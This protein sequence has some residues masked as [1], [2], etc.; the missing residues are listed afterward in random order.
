M[1]NENNAPNNCQ[2]S[3]VNYQSL[4]KKYWGYD[5]FRGIQKEIIESIGAGKDTL[6]LMPT[7]GGK[8]ITFQV[9]ALA[10]EG[11]CIVITPLIALMKDQ[12][13]N[14]RRRG[15]Q[16]SAIYS[17]MKHDSILMTLENAVF[18]GVKILYISPE[19]ISTSLFL[20]KLRHMKVSFI[21]VDEAH[22]ISQWGYDFRPSYL[23]IAD[24]RKELPDT[25]VLALTATATPEVIDD[26]QERLHFRE[27]CVY[28]MSFARKNLAYVVRH[29]SNKTGQLIH[30]LNHVQ[31][32]AIVYVR[33][34]KRTKEYAELLN[35]SGISATFY[36]AG[37]DN[38]EK[39]QRQKA[40]QEDKV[41]VMVATNAF[42]MG[43][44]KPDVR[45]VIHI[46]CP[47]CLEAYFQE[48]GRAGRDGKKSYAVLLYD[49]SDRA[50]LQRRVVDTFPDKDF[51]RQVY[52]QL[53]YFY[54]IGVGSGYNACFEFP[55]ERF[56]RIYKHFPIPTVSALNILTRAGY[57]DFKEEDDMQARVM[58]SVER[59]DLYKLRGN[60]PQEDAVI[61]ALLRNYTGL[62][63]GY[64]YIDEGV[65]AEQCGLTQPQVYMTLRALT[66]KHILDFIPQK[67]IPFIRYTQRREES[68]RLVI[69]KSIYD[70]LKI[71]FAER[72]EKML[73][74]ANSGNICRSRML[75]RYFGETNTED[76]GQ[77]DVCLNQKRSWT[78]PES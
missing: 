21:C 70:D 26:I 12:V 46:D 49:N 15:I 53:A 52:D 68:E 4:L 38:Q 18:G 19:R 67:H 8:S 72:I 48:A 63:Q 59:D 58:F 60:E 7:G 11:V 37:L 9:P 16:A 41:R 74:Y 51:I 56:C 57:I 54:Q 42:G 1:D 3:I 77:C 17:G 6:G 2:L 31:G 25:P 78:P 65:I 10:H 22:C 29:T 32:S 13:S 14:L 75:L 64:Q 69:S 43:I 40:W 76:C 5:D 30:I 66:Q 45:V 33:S 71:R 61:V 24:I 20:E 62:F 55:L 28:K 50:K 27:K 23:S 44:D 34:R 35:T 73:E 47:D 36:H 39:D